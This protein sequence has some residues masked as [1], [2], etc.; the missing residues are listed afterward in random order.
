[1]RYLMAALAIVACP[2]HLPLLLVLL[3]GTAFG[4]GLSEHMAVAFI[5]LTA[6]FGLSAW[7]ALRMFSQSGAGGRE[8][9]QATTPKVV[10][11]SQEPG[12]RA[13]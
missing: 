6:L 8:A 4:A 11:A 3:G 13:R 2:C 1:M 10:E 9:R 12:G 7:A 5:A